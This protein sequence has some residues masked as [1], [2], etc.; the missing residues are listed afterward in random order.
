MWSKIGF[1]LIFYYFHSGDSQDAVTKSSL[2][3][4]EEERLSE[5]IANA[6]DHFKKPD[7]VGLPGAKIPDPYHVPEIKKSLP[8]GGSIVFKNTS[9]YGISKFR[10]LYVNVEAGKMEATA[11]LSIDKVHAKG[12]YVL[13]TW[14]RTYPGNYQTDVEGIKSIAT[15]SLE[16]DTDGKIKA[17]NISMDISFNNIGVQFENSG[18]ISMVLQGLFNSMGIFLFNSIKP[19]ILKDAYTKLREEI[20]KKLEIV[21]GDLQFP[22]SISPIDMIL[23]KAR[24]KVIAL[25]KDP[26]KIKNY[27]HSVSMFHVALSQTKLTGLSSFY[28]DGN[29]TLKMENNTIIIDLSIG[30]QEIQ[31]S[32][33]WEISTFKGYFTKVGTVSFSINYV[34]IRIILGQ[35][36][37]TRKRPEF[38]NLDVELGNLQIRFD[39]A[40]TI[41]YIVELAINILPNI[42]RNQIIVA[43]DDLVRIKIQRELNEVNVEDLIKEFLPIVDKLQLKGLSLS[44]FFPTQEENRYD[45]DDFF[46]F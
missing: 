40:G 21:A 30:T 6:I 15:A 8:L 23:I 27:N 41:D 3:V 4:E 25:E 10:V 9:L 26:Y 39:G 14:L 19:Y 46:N 36:L 12:K 33:N 29:T 17:Q 44:Q 2:S 28:R 11:A 45:E 35:P 16:V 43:F 7:P 13:S 24:N 42:L 31:G 22:T 5:F 34:R 1:F 32:T 18:I 37:D 38:R 20:N